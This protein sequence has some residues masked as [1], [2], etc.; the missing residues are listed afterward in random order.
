MHLAGHPEPWGIRAGR[1]G[2]DFKK[3]MARKNRLIK[4]FADCRVKQLNAGK[5]EFIR[6]NARFVDA[7][8]V[9]L[10]RERRLPAGVSHRHQSKDS[11]A[12]SRRSRKL[13]AKNFIIATGSTIAPPPLLP[14][15]D[16]EFITSDDALALKRLPQSLIVLGGGPTACE[17]AQFFARF[18]VKVTLIQRS[19]HILKEFDAG[20]GGGNRKSFPAGRHQGLHRHEAGGRKAERKTQDRFV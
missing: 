4:D 16:V 1:V 14:L 13:T 20:R 6:A 15:N 18:G 12:G 19:Q 17:F 7:H 11:L 2:F 5:F 8:T 3:V 10:T 9:E